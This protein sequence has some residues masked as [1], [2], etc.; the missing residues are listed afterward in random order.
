[1]KKQ[2]KSK[3]AEEVKASLLKKLGK[4]MYAKYEKVLD[5]FAWEIG[6]DTNGWAAELG[7][8]E[9]YRKSKVGNK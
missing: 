5:E 8:Y 2:M 6:S 9:N 7:A 3:T 4:E 1:M